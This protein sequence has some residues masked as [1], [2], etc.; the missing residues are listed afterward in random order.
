MAGGGRVNWM[1]CQLVPALP[2]QAA[3]LIDADNF[4][5][6]PSLHAAWQ[7]FKCRAGG[8]VS[9]CRAYGGAAR[10]QA[11]SAVWHSLAARCMP[12]LS[13]EKNT[14]DAALVA[15]AVAL[16]FQQGVRLFAVASGDADFAPLATRLREWGCEVWCFSMEG[17]LF[18]DAEY[19]YD[20]VIRF[21]PALL[22][23]TSPVPVQVAP[24]PLKP[25]TAPV[26]VQVAPAPLK[27]ITA[28]VPVRLVPAPLVPVTSPVPVQ[29][30]PAPQ[31]P[32]TSP[33][34]DL[35]EDVVRVLKAVP[36]LRQTPQM[37]SVVVPVLRQKTIFGKTTKST[38]FFARYSAYFKLTPAHQPIELSYLPPA[39]AAPATAP[40]TLPVL[41]LQKPVLPLHQP[42]PS[43]PGPPVLSWPVHGS[44]RA[45]PPLLAELHGLRSVLVKLALR[46]VV[47]ADVLL[48]VPEL[49][50]G[51]ACALSSVAGRLRE[52]SLLHFGQSSLRIFEQHPTSFAIDNPRTPQ[53][54]TYLR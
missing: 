17:I 6:V 10:L 39:A 2:Q 40:L 27:P 43:P 54:V 41:P 20:R 22:P 49:L 36:D 14:T 18:A 42:V 11:L 4:A 24:P 32:K 7:Q 50:G 1:P 51:Q 46:R 5:D 34:P 48:A 35:P 9:V 30:T 38:A 23:A 44:R 33:G 21:A 31:E 29:A 26:S 25:I 12:N 47:V 15:D 13:L 28:P 19:F 53:S 37:L 52:K 16:H 3:L 8:R 45:A